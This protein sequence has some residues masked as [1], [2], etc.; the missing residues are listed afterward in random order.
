MSSENRHAEVAGAGIAGLAVATALAQRGWDVTVHERF[1]TVREVGAGIALGRNGVEALAALGALEET[2]A[3]GQEISSWSI[4]DEWGR[5][6]QDEKVG[7]GM[8]YSCR[9][10]SLQRALLHAAERQGVN[11]VTDSPVTGVSNGRLLIEGGTS[12]PADLIV[13]A[14]GVGSRVRRS[15]EEEGSIRVKRIDL[16]AGSLRFI[17]PRRPEDPVT[18]TPEWIVGN[19][20][21]GLLPLDD[22]NIAMYMFCPPSDKRGRNLPLDKESWIASF[23]HLR[24]VFDRLPS[25]G[26]WLPVIETHC[27]RWTVGNTALLGDAAF[28]MAPNMG[29][30]GSTALH[31]AIT[32]ADAVSGDAPVETALPEWESR[33]RDYVDYAQSWSGRYS[34]MVSQ[35]PPIGRKI[36]S[37]VFAR[38]SRS[39]RLASRFAGVET[40]SNAMG[41]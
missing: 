25:E 22:E 20:R 1:P 7:A 34:H 37:S 13:G 23:P 28:S 9:R 3:D 15:L 4:G 39:E 16:K 32:L 27:S 14:D 30:G 41:R 24:S 36:R 18:T 10:E 21:V 11:V 12:L 33:L 26:T 31:V 2:I 29:Q 5:T 17:I 40:R 8:L 19:R 38:L 6:V 35:W